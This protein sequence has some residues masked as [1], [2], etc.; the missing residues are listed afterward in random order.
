MDKK[1][2]AELRK[3]RRK[4]IKLQNTSSRKLT[5]SEAIL[6]VQNPVE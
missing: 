3:I 2:K 5:M 6:L 1:K 4:A